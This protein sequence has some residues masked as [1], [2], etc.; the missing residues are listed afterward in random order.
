MEPKPPS[1]WHLAI[2]IVITTTGVVLILVG[3][4]VVTPFNL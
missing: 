4:D 1:L 2:S 3:Q